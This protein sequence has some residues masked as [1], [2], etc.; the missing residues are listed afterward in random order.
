MALGAPT[1]PDLHAG[2]ARV[3]L[4]EAAKMIFLS[5]GA[6]TPGARSFL[7]TTPNQWLEKPFEIR[8]LRSIINEPIR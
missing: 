5:G 2:L 8:E 1:E 4:E 3:C 7:D 6:F